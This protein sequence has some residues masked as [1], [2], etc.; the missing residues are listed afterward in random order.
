MTRP[1]HTPDIQRLIDAGTLTAGRRSRAD[2]WRRVLVGVACVVLVV[3]IF[4]L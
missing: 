2:R 1:A 4:A 3:V